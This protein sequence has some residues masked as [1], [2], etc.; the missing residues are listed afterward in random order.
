MMFDII[1][2][3]RICKKYA[4]YKKIAE[5]L[6]AEYNINSYIGTDGS[7]HCG[8]PDRFGYVALEC[9]INGTDVKCIMF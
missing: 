2:F 6:K 4:N 1:A 7:L 8:Y 5:A 3:N 9:I